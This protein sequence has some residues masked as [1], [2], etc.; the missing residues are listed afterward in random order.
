MKCS[1]CSHSA[2][3]PGLCKEHFIVSFEKKVFDTIEKYNLLKKTDRV[4]VATSGGK[5]S[6]T[7]LYL[8]KKWMGSQSV[9]EALVVDEGIAGYRD[10]TVTDL[11]TFCRAHKITLNTCSFKNDFGIT[12]DDATKKVAVTPC[13]ICGAWRRALLNKYA[14]GFDKVATGHN[15]D[16]ECQAIMMNY[17]R[18][19]V[20]LSAR[21]GPVSG[22]E[23]IAGFVQR[24][25]PLY[26]CCE[27]EVRLY[28]FLMGFVVGFSECPNI[29]QS[30]RAQVRDMLNEWEQGEPGIKLKIVE[31]FMKD[32]STF[33]KKFGS[34]AAV[35][36]CSH[37]AQPSKN[38]VCSACAFK[39]AVA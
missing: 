22:V 1:L 25:K 13:H 2:V 36:V 26:F 9:V 23:P 29:H 20:E 24:V 37:C 28:A 4:C 21:L 12:L 35:G 6:L 8:V 3:Y 7:V 39:E 10:H 30:Y 16:D 38:K 14:Q 34:L 32:L 17:L 5:D 27:K 15:L 11:E 31:Q 19:T 33:K 18:S